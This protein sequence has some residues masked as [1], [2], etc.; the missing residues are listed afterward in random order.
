MIKTSDLKV[1]F[2][3]KNAPP[4][5]D[6]LLKLLK[7]AYA[8]E[9]QCWPAVIKME[10][11]KPFSDFRYEMTEAVFQHFLKKMQNGVHPKL[12]VY[13][14]GDKFIM[15]DDYVKYQFCELMGYE[16]VICMVLGKPTGKY[17]EKLAEPVYLSFP[18]SIEIINGVNKK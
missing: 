12:I 17:V 3:G 15:S 10:G 11:I 7:Q 9:F 6:K 1:E 5:D 8:K 18:E 2:G 13:Q 4:K 14:E 16:R